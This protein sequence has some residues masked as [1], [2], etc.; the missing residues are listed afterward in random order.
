MMDTK[1]LMSGIAVVIDDALDVDGSLFSGDEPAA[2]EGDRINHIV[3]WFEQ[4]WELPFVK[5]RTL[6]DERHWSNLLHAASF[7]LLDWR[8]W[9]AGGATL[10]QATVVDI[11]RFLKIAREN[12]VPVF[13]FTNESPE[14]VTSELPEDVYADPATGRSFVFVGRKDEVWSD[15][16]VDVGILDDWI[17]TNASVY[18]LKTWEQVV[19][20]AKGELFRAMCARS[21]DWPRVF[22]N[23]YVTDG[24]EPSASL[25]NLINDSLRGRMQADAFEEEHLG[26]EFE[27]V[28]GDDLRTLI[29]ETSFRLAEFLPTDEIRCGDL[30]KGSQG[31]YWLNMRPDCDCIPRDEGDS[32]DVEVYCVQGKKVGPS[33]LNNRYQK[34]TGHFKER[35]FESV[36]FAI[37]DGRSV[38]FNF[39]KLRVMKFSEVR[40]ERIG[41]LLHPYLTRV[42]QRYALYMQ[43]QALPRIPESAVPGPP[44]NAP[45]AGELP[46]GSTSG[47]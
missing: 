31:K 10:K 16:S 34:K 30:Y 41:R 19:G 7:V 18:A 25:T 33:N 23:A 26:G 6:P 20:L 24:A 3:E 46:E 12:L 39:R 17:H 45:P 28:S 21:M 8:L 13:I 29:A 14:D 32:G 35:V 1:D 22:W 4:E 47:A 42:Q 37:V 40:E 44:P 15:E 2:A 43:R 36:A 11:I 27:D 9:G 38:V 5:A